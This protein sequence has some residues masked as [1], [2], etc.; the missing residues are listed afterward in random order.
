MKSSKDFYNK[1]TIILI[2][3]LLIYS[4]S[5]RI[6]NLFKITDSSLPSLQ[7]NV[8]DL[9]D[10]FI[11]IGE[12]ISQAVVGIS[13]TSYVKPRYSADPYQNE[14]FKFF[15]GIPEQEFRQSGVGSG[16]IVDPNGYI[17]TNE[18]V[19]SKADEITVILP[20]ERKFKGVL[21]GSDVRSDLAVIKISAENLPYIEMGDSNTVKPGQWAL[22][23]GNPFATFD[24]LERN[25]QPTMTLGIVSAI[26]R[27]LPTSDMNKRYYGDL[28]QTD[29]AINPGNS[30]GPL[31]DIDGR[32]IGINVAILS[33]TGQNA[34]IGFAL[35]INNAK[36]ILDNLIKGIDVKYGWLGVAIQSLSDDL[37]RKFGVA[38]KRGVLVARVMPDGPADRAGIKRGDIIVQFG[39]HKILA[40]DDLIRIVGHTNIDKEVMVQIYRNGQPLT[41]PVTVAERGTTGKQIV[42]AMTPESATWRG[43]TVQ[44]NNSEIRQRFQLEDIEGVVVTDVDAESPAGLTKIHPGDMIDEIDRKPVKNIDDFKT[45]TDNLSGDILIHTFNI[46]YIVVKEPK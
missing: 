42:T 33:N 12:N 45:I 8:Y 29:A 16:F 1:L 41:L 37:L 31:V 40:P 5:G 14:L 20:D 27:N 19:V 34:G 15:F 22:A 44:N 4:N 35:P 2:T 25:P 24:N 7:A 43:I 26:H 17:L 6:R 9:Q 39:D 10:K 11:N 3:G 28:I 30:G 32:V 46:G 38:D 13:I 21:C 23:I 36:R 18:H